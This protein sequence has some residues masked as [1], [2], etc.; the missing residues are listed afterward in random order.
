MF[1][2]AV[3]KA[4]VV[5]GLTAWIAL[6][7]S[8]PKM[9]DER[10]LK[11]QEDYLKSHKRESKRL[12]EPRE[13]L[14]QATLFWMFAWLLFAVQLIIQGTNSPLAYDYFGDYAVNLGFLFL[15]LGVFRTYH[16]VEYLRDGTYRPRI[17]LAM[18]II[19][20]GVS[21][22]DTGYAI[23]LLL[24]LPFL[25]TTITLAGRI[26]M[27]AFVFSIADSGVFI[28]FLIDDDLH[29]NQ[30]MNILTYLIGVP[31]YFL[32]AFLLVSVLA[33]TGLI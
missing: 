2:N 14:R 27:F 13:W 15:G 3:V 30:T 29:S 9:I 18:G 12:T 26:L 33:A 10:I 22:I 6:G 4:F 7:I 16:V 24:L 20:V 19:L 8:T 28:K 23:L 32:V 1:D 21:V 31:A 25:L 11:N 5:A 17:P